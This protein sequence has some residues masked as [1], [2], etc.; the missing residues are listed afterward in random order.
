MQI[1]LVEVAQALLNIKIEYQPW[2]YTSRRFTRFFSY[3]FCFYVS[4]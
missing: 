2:K 4:S 1:V 3:T